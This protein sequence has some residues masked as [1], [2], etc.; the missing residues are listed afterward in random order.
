MTLPV[1]LAFAFLAMFVDAMVCHSAKVKY[2]FIP[3]LFLA[4]IWPVAVGAA[5]VFIVKRCSK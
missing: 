2:R 5:I 3:S 1:Y 4:A